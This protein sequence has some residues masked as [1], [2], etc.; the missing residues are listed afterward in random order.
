MNG[1]LLLVCTAE[2]ED[3]PIGLFRTKAQA[4]AYAS[5]GVP[6]QEIQ[7]AY[8]LYRGGCEVHE[9]PGALE[10]VVIQFKGGKA[11]A[12]NAPELSPDLFA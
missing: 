5:R 7:D 6:M 2:F 8:G 9:P 11:V 3:I 12:S 1:Y 4:E 10:F